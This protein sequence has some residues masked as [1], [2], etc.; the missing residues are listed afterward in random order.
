MKIRFA[1]TNA[2]SLPFTFRDGAIGLSTVDPIACFESRWYRQRRRQ[3]RQREDLRRK[4]PARHAAMTKRDLFTR[5]EINEEI[6]EQFR[7]A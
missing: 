3:R 5:G 7:W 1:E 6:D 2:A 4:N